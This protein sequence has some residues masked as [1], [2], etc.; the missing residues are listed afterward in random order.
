MA[1]VEHDIDALEEKIRTAM[2]EVKNLDKDL[3]E[4]VLQVI[5]LPG[6]T[7]SAEFVFAMGLTEALVD[8]LVLARK[9]QGALI[10]GARRVETP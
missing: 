4:G 6:W 2:E 1:E 8:H 3:L 7:S 5:R 10:A 9:M